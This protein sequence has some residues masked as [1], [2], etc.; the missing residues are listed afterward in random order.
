ML[1]GR[2]GYA[3]RDGAWRHPERR[4][5]FIGDLVDRGTGVGE[6]LDTIRAMVE[7]GSA[8]AIL[9][10]H[11]Y[12]LLC[13]A[14]DEPDGHSRCK[15]NPKKLEEQKP[16][17]AALAERPDRRDWLF[18][19]PLWLEIDGARFVHAYWG[20]REIDALDGRSTLAACGWEVPWFRKTPLGKAAERLL[21][22]PEVDLPEG[23]TVVDKHGSV[24]NEVRVAWWRARRE[25]AGWQEIVLPALGPDGPEGPAP[26]EVAQ[27]YDPYP[28]DAPPV[29]IG[30]YGFKVFPGLLAP[31][32]ACVD[33]GNGNGHIGA[34]RWDGERTFREDSFV[35]VD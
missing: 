11:E 20:A 27:S 3:E 30:H 14:V 25:G 7:A 15:L 16:S 24:R 8:R 23:R 2:L 10:N 29:F 12:N 31:N 9:G 18:A 34:Y 32:V 35:V 26:A 33:Y 17:M 4:A 6:V 21:K 5:L 13:R 28:A 22:G 1:L 19:L